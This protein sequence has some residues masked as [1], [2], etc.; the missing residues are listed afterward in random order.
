MQTARHQYTDLRALELRAEMPGVISNLLGWGVY[1]P[2]WWRNFKHSHS[3]YEVCYVYAGSGR[4]F[5]NGESL[6]INQHD[7]FIARP[8]DLHEIITADGSELGIIFWSFTLTLQ[9]D[10]MNPTN[11]D[12]LFESFVMGDRVIANRQELLPLLDSF[13]H[14]LRSLPAGYQFGL[15]AISQKLLLETARAFSDAQVSDQTVPIMHDGSSSLVSGVVRFLHDN[16]HRPLLLRDVASQFHLS[17]RHVNRLFKQAMGEPIMS[18]LK[19][20]RIDRAKEL[21]LV[22]KMKVGEVAAAVGVDDMRYF[23]TL[24]RQRTGVTPTEFRT[25]SGTQFEES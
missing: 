20:L 2:K 6:D 24:F 10:G 14:E 8:N 5:I 19:N 7:L 23:S 11:L 16:Y 22:E 9:P 25:N 4:F 15:Q 18:Y 17:E 12:Q 13:T 21:L 1:E 3:Y